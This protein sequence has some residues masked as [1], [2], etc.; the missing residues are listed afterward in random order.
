MLKS[1]AA[2]LGK[3]ES[4]DAVD[5]IVHTHCLSVVIRRF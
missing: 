5:N 2:L 4:D 3:Y 1:F